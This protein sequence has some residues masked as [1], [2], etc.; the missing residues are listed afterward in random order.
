[1]PDPALQLDTAG[2]IATL[3]LN[4]PDKRNA[5]TE[6]MWN[7]LPGLLKQAEKTAS[8]HALVVTGAG[9]AFA[10]GADIGEFERIY[11]T[12]ES[13]KAYSA[14]VSSALDALAGF[15]KPTVAK[16]SGPCIGGGCG[17]ALACDLRFADGSATF[18]VTPAKLGLIYPLND[19]KRLIEA[20]GVSAAKDMLFTGRIMGAEEAK[21]L[22]L[23]DRLCAAGALEGEIADWLSR[24]RAASSYSAREMKQLIAMIQ[25]GVHHETGESRQ[26]FL[27][28]FRGPHFAE[29]YKAFMEKREPRF[30]DE[31]G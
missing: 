3:T 20:A 28:A 17:L 4:R 8:V 22:G 6:A 15:P 18:G 16:I 5:L 23:I 21:A 12:E 26:M 1:M 11:A 2:E 14:T 7:A 25:R 9:G 30:P 19:T 31:T 29:G 10:A 24:V 13:A 27:D